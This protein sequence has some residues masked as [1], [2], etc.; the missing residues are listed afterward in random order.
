MV[1]HQ[2]ITGSRDVATMTVHPVGP[3]CKQCVDYMVDAGWALV[4]ACASVGIEHGRTT[5]QEMRRYMATIH[6][7]HRTAV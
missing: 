1:T 2:T 4:H 7:G 3:T 6:L 5:E